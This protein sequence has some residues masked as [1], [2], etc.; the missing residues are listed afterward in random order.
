MQMKWRV[1]KFQIGNRETQVEIPYLFIF[2]LAFYRSYII[3]S[4]P[5]SQIY[6]RLFYNNIMSLSDLV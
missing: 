3:F 1:F 6:N 4:R 2:S 5:S